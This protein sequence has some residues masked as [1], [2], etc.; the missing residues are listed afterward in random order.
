[1]GMRESI[2][3]A[4]ESIDLTDGLVTRPLRLKS[5]KRSVECIGG[6]GQWQLALIRH[7]E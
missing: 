6:G 3:A 4:A 2:F 1:M 7:N 5:N